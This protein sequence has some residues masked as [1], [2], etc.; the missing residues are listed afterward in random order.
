MSHIDRAATARGIGGLKAMAARDREA[1][2]NDHR[3]HACSILEEVVRIPLPHAKAHFLASLGEEDI[4]AFIGWVEIVA[5]KKVIGPAIERLVAR[6]KRPP[7]DLA[8]V[9]KEALDKTLF[10]FEK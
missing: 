3:V 6:G 10:S 7:F 8:E 4:Y 9:F 2:L 5:G 1:F